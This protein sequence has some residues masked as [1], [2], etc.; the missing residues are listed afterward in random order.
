MINV[1]VTPTRR[2]RA[3][4]RRGVRRETARLIREV[5]VRL[6]AY[7]KEEAPQPPSRPPPAYQRTGTLVRSI[8]FNIA[9]S[10]GL[11]IVEAGYAAHV[12][13]RQG[14]MARAIARVRRDLPRLIQRVF[15]A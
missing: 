14:Y 10:E 9:P 2:L 13:R 12:E 3:R 5:T 4:L 7:G 1:R 11:V 15:G 6:A 8:G